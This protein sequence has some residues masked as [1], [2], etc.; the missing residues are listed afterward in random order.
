MIVDLDRL[1]LAPRP[2]ERT[3]N[4]IRTTAAQIKMR[5]P[6]RRI[7]DEPRRPTK[8]LEFRLTVFHGA[9]HL[10]AS[11][12]VAALTPHVVAVRRIS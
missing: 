8:A 6:F 12:R 5:F 3:R 2:C 4:G 1:A 11:T 9:G 10:L 7:A